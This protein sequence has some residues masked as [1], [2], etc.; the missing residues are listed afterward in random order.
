MPLRWYQSAACQAVWDFLC[1]RLGN[2]VVCLPT[3]SGKSLVIGQ[4]CLDAIERWGGRVIVLAHRKELLTQNAEKIRDAA[5]GLDVGIYSAGLGARNTEQGVIVAGIQSVFRRAEEFGQRHLVLIDEV[6]LVPHGGE[7]MYRRFLDDLRAICPHVRMAGLTAT[8]Y[9]LDSGPIC[10]PDGLFHR[11]CY[12]APIRPLIAEGFLCNLTTRPAETTVDTSG[13]HLRGGEFIPGETERLFS[14][15]VTGACQELVAKAAGRRSVLVFCSGVAHAAQVAAELGRLTG[16]P[17]GVV[18]GESLPIERDAVLGQFKRGRLRW[19]CNVDVLTTGFDAPGIN[20][21]A[22]LRATMSPGLF[23]QIVGRGFRVAPE[24]Q[25]CL[26]LDFGGNIRRH[27]PIDDPAYGIQDTRQKTA[28]DAP[29]KVCPNCG[30]EVLISA[31]E[32]PECGWQFPR[33]RDPKHDDRA[34]D[35]K[36]LSEPETWIVEMVSYVRHTKRKPGPDDRPTLRVDY[37]ARKEGVEGNLKEEVISEWVCLEHDGFAGRK[38]ARWWRKRSAAAVPETI[39]EAVDLA[40]RGAVSSP[41]S[42]TLARQGRWWRVLSADLDER[43]ETWADEVSGDDP[44]ATVGQEEEIP[45]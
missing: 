26:V 35:S 40:Q 42:I 18:T 19:V 36:I 34:D 1:Q 11:V 6:H 43:P 22:V 4:L 30:Q 37:T 7:G 16:E 20:C 12:S 45:F 23:A 14:G 13:L 9:R 25:D 8:P 3:G 2:P 10:R 24:K 15:V 21:I 27:G 44:F 5:P 28:G 39:D 41:R 33:D 29:T 17:V 31:T 38:A 32:C